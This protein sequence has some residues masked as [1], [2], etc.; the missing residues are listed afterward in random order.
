MEGSKIKRKRFKIITSLHDNQVR[1]NNDDEEDYGSD[2]DNNNLTRKEKS[3]LQTKH[4]CDICHNEDPS[5]PEFLRS[6]VK[7]LDSK[8]QSILKFKKDRPIYILCKK[9]YRNEVTNWFSKG[10]VQKLFL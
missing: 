4:N 7:F 6:E 10:G 1:N 8:E 9:H 2:S 5:L 3:N